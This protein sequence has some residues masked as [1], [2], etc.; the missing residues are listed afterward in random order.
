MNINAD[1]TNITGTIK[2]MHGI[3]QPP[4]LGHNRSMYHYLADAGIPFSRLHDVG[5]WMGRGLYV[6][7]PNLFRDFDADEN[8]PASYDFAFTDWLMERICET[9]CEPFFRLGVTIENGHMLK[10]YRIFPP[11][12]PHKWARICEHVIRHYNEGWANGYHMGIR[13]WEI[14]NE[15]DDCWKNETSAMWKGTKEAYF[16]LYAVTANHLKA[17]FGDSIRVGGYA[18]CGFYAMDADP[19]RNG[20]RGQNEANSLQEFF[21]IFMREFFIYISSEEHRAPLDFFSWHSYTD[22]KT[23][24]RHAQYCRDVMTEYGFG[25][26][27]DILNEWNTTPD[28]YGRATPEAAAKVLAMMLGM[29]KTATSIL[30]FYDGRLGPS[31]YGGLFNPSTWEPYLAYYALKMFNR[32][33][34]MKHEVYS[35][36]DNEDVFVLAARGENN[37]AC[38]LLSNISGTEQNVQLSIK[39]VDPKQAEVFR[40]DRKNPY[41]AT[42]ESV[43]DGSI[44][45]P[46]YACVEIVFP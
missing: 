43:S 7:I 26:T 22:V 5:G 13:Y 8:D 4:M 17:C 2:P 30:C 28:I 40:I 11:K 41:R 15:P 19:E 3:G 24:L 21:L 36:S 25:D 18:S 33:Y 44:I 46:P 20:M 45:L 42:G 1:Y 32:A 38:L 37:G 6:D 10:A 23:T 14:W 29:Q 12:D 39:G 35:V 34:Q 31:E 27:E 16:E 9:G